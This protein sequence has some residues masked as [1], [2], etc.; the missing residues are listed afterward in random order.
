MTDKYKF[1]MKIVDGTCQRQIIVNQRKIMELKKSLVNKKFD[2][3]RI[4][5]VA[6]QI[7]FLRGKI[8][9]HEQMM[10]ICQIQIE[11]IDRLNK[12]AEV[13]A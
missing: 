6:T 4:S 12:L 3:E 7:A 1:T 10:M 11:E 2:Y 13:E 8:Q 5:A 9:A